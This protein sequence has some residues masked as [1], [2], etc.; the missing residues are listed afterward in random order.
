MAVPEVQ[1]G[2]NAGTQG[3]LAEGAACLDDGGE[4]AR[5]AT[6]KSEQ[7]EGH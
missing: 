5:Q 2:P 7:A 3:A 1:Q 6:R 4:A